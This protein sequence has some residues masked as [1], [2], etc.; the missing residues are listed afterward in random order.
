VEIDPEGSKKECSEVKP[1]IGRI[2]RYVN[3]SSEEWPAII[4]AVHGDESVNLQV[5]TSPT[6]IPAAKVPF[7]A[8]GGSFSW[9]WPERAN[10]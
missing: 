3:R 7:D 4:V 6:V 5:F 1:T 8:A 9:H 10:G 2:V